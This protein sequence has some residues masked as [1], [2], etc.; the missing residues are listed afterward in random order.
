MSSSELRTTIPA[1]AITPIMDVA[2]KYW[3]SSA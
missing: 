1:S 3:P 2:V